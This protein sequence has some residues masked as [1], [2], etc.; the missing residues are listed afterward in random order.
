[1]I[2]CDWCNI[3]AEENR[4]LLLKTAEWSVYLADEQD[5]IGRCIVVL[6]RHAG[7][8]SELTISEWMVLKELID[9]L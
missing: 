2:I 5:Y 6:H 1:M 7:S 8:L 4:W 9:R 3:T